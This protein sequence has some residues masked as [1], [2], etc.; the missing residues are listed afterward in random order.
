MNQTE[1]VN[2]V[3]ELVIDETYSDES[4]IKAI[5]EFKESLQCS[6]PPQRVQVNL[7]NM[8]KTNSEFVAQLIIL[9]QVVNARDAELSITANRL[10]KRVFDI[11]ML[12]KIITVI[13]SD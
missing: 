2:D 8:L 9:S 13:Y 1:K 11:V 4:A 10:L 12:E 7:K 3:V 5:E 6:E